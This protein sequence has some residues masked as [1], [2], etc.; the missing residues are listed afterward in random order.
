MRHSASMSLKALRQSFTCSGTN[1]MIFTDLGKNNYTKRSNF[2]RLFHWNRIVKVSFK[3]RLNR[4]VTNNHHCLLNW[5]HC[6]QPHICVTRPRWFIIGTQHTKTIYRVVHNLK[7]IILRSQ[8]TIP[9][10]FDKLFVSSRPGRAWHS[11]KSYICTLDYRPPGVFVDGN[12]PQNLTIA[13][14][15]EVL[16]KS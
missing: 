15:V 8:P 3:Y 7:C 11:R 12:P 13:V 16:C 1:E 5:W 9:G 10:R 4:P 6:L 14:I 2:F